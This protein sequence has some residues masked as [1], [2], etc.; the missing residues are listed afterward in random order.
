MFQLYGMKMISVPHFFLYVAFSV[1][2]GAGLRMGYRRRF[3]FEG[4]SR[5][6]FD[7]LFHNL[8]FTPGPG[9]DA[10]LL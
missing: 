7:L 8:L 9:T 4:M 2:G 5:K 10:A 6:L 3:D 1:V